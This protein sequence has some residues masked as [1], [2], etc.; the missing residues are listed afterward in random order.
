MQSLYR[1]LKPNLFNQ[2]RILIRDPL[3]YGVLTAGT[4]SLLTTCTSNTTTVLRHYSVN[5][6]KLINF[7]GLNNVIITFISIY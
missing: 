4:T 3:H 6:G 1:V 2:M 7:V 5:N